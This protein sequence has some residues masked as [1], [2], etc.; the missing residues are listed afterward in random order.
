MRLRVRQTRLQVLLRV[1][2]VQ[3]NLVLQ[4]SAT[5]QQH[6]WAVGHQQHQENQ[7]VKALQRVMV[8]PLRFP[9]RMRMRI[10]KSILH[11]NSQMRLR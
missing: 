2:A 8:K 7:A 11:Q 10:R 4:V 5:Q 1:E 3:A 6:L 9:V